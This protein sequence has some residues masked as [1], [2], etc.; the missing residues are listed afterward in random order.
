M[1]KIALLTL[2]L[3]TV[4]PTPAP[5]TQFSVRLE[6]G[7]TDGSSVYAV[8]AHGITGLMGL[9]LEIEYAPTTTLGPLESG[10]LGKGCIGLSTGVQPSTIHLSI[11]CTVPVD[12]SGTLIKFNLRQR[13]TR[14]SITKCVFNEQ[15]C[16]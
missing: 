15:P 6:R 11:A 4:A 1:T 5:V 16:E 12:G 8:V 7:T 2:A 3:L 13:A 9:D 10:N 14:V